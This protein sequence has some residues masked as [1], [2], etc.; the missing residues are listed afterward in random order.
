MSKTFVAKTTAWAT[1]ADAPRSETLA[2]P[3]RGRVGRALEEPR[4][5]LHRGGGKEDGGMK[6]AP[7]HL[8]DRLHHPGGD[9]RRAAE[10]EEVVRGAE[11]PETKDVFP[12]LG[13]LVLEDVGGLLML[14]HPSGRGEAAVRPE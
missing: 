10:V 11:W 14:G 2:A 4:E 13:K 1:P 9:E 6:R 7:M 3:A 5:T 12:D 8:R